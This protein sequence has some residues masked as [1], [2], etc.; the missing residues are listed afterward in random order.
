[1]YQDEGVIEDDEQPQLTLIVSLLLLV[2]V[3]VAIIFSAEY[4]VDSIEGIGKNSGLNKIFVSLILLPIATNAT[5]VI[6]NYFK[7]C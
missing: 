7:F 2:V 4:L 5:V 3:T 6:F 1:L